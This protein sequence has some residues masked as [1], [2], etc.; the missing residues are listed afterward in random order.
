MTMAK[1]TLKGIDPAVDAEI[2]MLKKDPAV[3]LAQVERTLKNRYKRY[4][5]DLR[6]LKKR[7]EQL[8]SSGITESILREWSDEAL[9]AIREAEDDDEQV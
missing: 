2:E 1:T 6:Y 5:Y 9:A 8:I 4:L 3:R 7:G